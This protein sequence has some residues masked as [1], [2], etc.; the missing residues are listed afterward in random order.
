MWLVYGAPRTGSETGFRDVP[1]SNNVIVGMDFQD[2]ALALGPLGWVLEIEVGARG[3]GRW[4]RI[5]RCCRSGEEETQ[6][7][8]WSEWRETHCMRI[9]SEKMCMEYDTRIESEK[10][11]MKDMPW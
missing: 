6:G 4:A 9:G 1:G 2:L 10:I 7:Q 11:D 8:E 3:I 5:E